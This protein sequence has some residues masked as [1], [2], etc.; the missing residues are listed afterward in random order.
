M[1]RY[2]LTRNQYNVDQAAQAQA[3]KEEYEANPNKCLFCCSS[4][5]YKSKKKFCNNSCSAKYSNANRSQLKEKI[6]SVCSVCNAEFE[7]LARKKKHVREVAQRKVTQ[8]QTQK[9]HQRKNPIR[10]ELVMLE[11]MQYSRECIS[12]D[13]VKNMLITK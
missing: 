6:L 8:I 2:K 9:R 3:R 1:S 10:L 4:L 7:Q 5:P 13:A 11:E 12:V